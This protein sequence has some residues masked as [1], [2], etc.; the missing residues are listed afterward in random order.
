MRRL[1]LLMIP[2]FCLAVWAPVAIAQEEP[3]APGEASEQAPE[4][5]VEPGAPAEPEEEAES[6]YDYTG[7]FVRVG[8]AYAAFDTD[9]SDIQFDD[10]NGFIVALGWRQYSWL[11]L[12]VSFAGFYGSK[13]DDYLEFDRVP[14]VVT[15]GTKS[16][17]SSEFSVTAKLYPL[18]I[19]AVREFGESP[20]LSNLPQIIQPY[21]AVGTGFGLQDVSTLDQTRAAFRFAGGLDVIVWEPVALT[22]EGGYTL[23]ENLVRRKSGTYITG[24]KFLNVGTTI[25]F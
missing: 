3:P 10:A 16:L 7:P 25:R 18:G 21:V 11:G 4:E 6:P 19:R 14:I 13:T 20:L 8:Y 12:E 9:E 24:T 1:R 15:D 17:T 23:Q 5:D 2:L 22:L